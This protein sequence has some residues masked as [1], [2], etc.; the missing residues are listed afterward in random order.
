MKRIVFF[1]EVHQ[2]RRIRKFSVRDIGKNRDYFWDAKNLEIIDRVAEKCYL[3]ATQALIDGNIKTSIS[4]SGVLLESLV[5]NR[6]DVVEKFKEYFQKTG[7]EPVV[8]TYYHSLSS[9]W[10]EREFRQQVEKD[11]KMTET[12]FGKTPTTFRNSELIYRDDLAAVVG[13]MGY[14][15]IIT[16][17][18]DALISSHSP[19]YIY[20]SKYGQNLLLRNYRL[21]DDISFRFSNH[22]WTEFPLFADKYARWLEETPGD[23]INLFMDYET[24]GEHQWRET[25][26]FEFLARLPEEVRKRGMEF[27]T[28]SEVGELLEPKATLSIPNY[29]SWADFSRDLS[30]WLGNDMQRDA[31]EDLKSF[32][33]CRDVEIWR[34]LQTSDH[35][36]YMSLANVQDQEVHAYFNPYGSPFD[37]YIHYKNVMEDM[38]IR[39]FGENF[40]KKK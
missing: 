31:F 25:G 37:A 19:N 39:C 4:I 33:N 15:N 18:T 29:I 24:F 22:S 30:A 6:S 21:S 3:P 34:Y 36:Y 5:K 40:K 27:S 2:P 11:S 28:I 35:L 26:I 8:E 12:V 9:I 7:G 16:E 14:R 23:I 1:F 20:S 13:G 17:G 32:E 38:R 10:N